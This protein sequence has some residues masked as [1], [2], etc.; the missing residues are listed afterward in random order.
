MTPLRIAIAGAG[1]IGRAHAQ[2]IRESGDCTLAAYADPS[3]DAAALAAESGVPLYTGLAELLEKERPD[4]VI[5]A[6]PNALHVPGAL[7]CLAAGV[8]V[9]VEKPVADTLDDAQRLVEAADRTQVPVLVG[10]HRRHSAILE[11]AVDTVRS[12]ALGQLVAVTASA[13]FVKPDSYFTDGPWRAQPGGGPILINLVHEIDNL[14]AL[15]GDIVEVQA[16]AS[17]ATRGHPVEDTV[18]INLRFANGALGTFM[19]SDCAASPRSWEQTAGENKRYDH[20]ADEDCYVIAGTHGS[21]EVPTMRLRQ[22]AGERSW[23]APLGTRRLHLPDVDPLQ[24]QLAH[25]CQVIRGEATPRVTAA[26]ARKTLQATLAVAE[27]ARTKR[28]VVVR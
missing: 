27:A 12:G 8:P 15:V 16:F 14:R 2:R 11:Q 7:L 4:G 25:F 13:T 21:L 28:A 9:L 3:P 5:L 18:A 23:W 17:R 20:H 6:T 22:Y 1:L 26:E 10:H 24:R 19:L